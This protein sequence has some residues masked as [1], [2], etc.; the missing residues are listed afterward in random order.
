MKALHGQVE[1][2]VVVCGG[3]RAFRVLERAEIIFLRIFEKFKIIAKTEIIAKRHLKMLFIRQWT[4]KLPENVISRV[5]S[6]SEGLN[7]CRC[8]V[9]MTSLE[10]YVSIWR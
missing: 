6:K 1:I 3:F 10:V 9:Q 4:K 2:L 5:L 7:A 8:V